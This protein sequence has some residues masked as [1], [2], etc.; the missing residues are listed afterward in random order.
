MEYLKSLSYRLKKINDNT[1][2]KDVFEEILKLE[3]K[4]IGFQKDQIDNHEGFDDK[5]LKR[6]SQEDSLYAPSTQWFADNKRPYPSLTKKPSG[7][8]YNFVWGGDFM[9]NFRIKR[10]DKGIEIYSTGTGIDDKLRFFEDYKNMFGLNTY[11]SEIILEEV[12]YYVMMKNL[13]NIYL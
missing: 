6:E 13:K 3:D 1:I 8:R 11:H 4:I 10:Q 7:E 5:D 2:R 9:N 12:F